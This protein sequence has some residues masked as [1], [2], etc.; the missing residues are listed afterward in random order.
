M[1]TREFN[2]FLEISTFDSHISI[3]EVKV[4]AIHDHMEWSGRHLERPLRIYIKKKKNSQH[5]QSD[6][7]HL[8]DR[9]C[10]PVRPPLRKAHSHRHGHPTVEAWCQPRHSPL[11]PF[12]GGCES[13]QKQIC[14][15]L[16]WQPGT[17]PDNV[18]C[19]S[20][21]HWHSRK[22]LIAPRTKEATLKDQTWKQHHSGGSQEWAR[23]VYHSSDIRQHSQIKVY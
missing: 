18:S 11:P 17:S 14:N 12:T 23:W 16:S 3:S 19:S 9:K 5:S 22:D 1:T 21:S 7:R 2:F 8:L 10:I 4:K 13:H 20:Q 6:G 15:P